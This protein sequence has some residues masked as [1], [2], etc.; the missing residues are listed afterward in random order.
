MLFLG[1]LQGWGSLQSEQPLRGLLA[2]S[3]FNFSLRKVWIHTKVEL[4]NEPMHPT[5]SFN[6]HQLLPMSLHPDPV[7]ALYGNKSPRKYYCNTYLH[8]QEFRLKIMSVFQLEKKT[9]FLNTMKHSIASWIYK[10]FCC[11]LFPF[12]WIRIQLSPCTLQLVYA[13]PIQ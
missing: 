4:N 11:M 2:C 1:L 3:F 6:Y 8:L 5:P 12:S 7:S 13:H 9:K 10:S